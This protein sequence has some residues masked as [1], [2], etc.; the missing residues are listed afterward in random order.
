AAAARA[1][2]LGGQCGDSDGAPAYWPGVQVLRAG[3]AAGGDPGAAAMVLP[4]HA[5]EPAVTADRFRLFDAVV[6]F[7]A[8]LAGQRPVVVVLDDLHW[9]D[10]GSLRLLEFTAR[11]VAAHPVLLLGAY[12]DEDGGALLSKLAASSEQLRLDGLA[13]DDV[14]ALMALVVG[15]SPAAEVAADVWR[16]TGGNPFLVRELTRLLVAQGGSPTAGGPPPRV[17]LDGVADILERR[18]A[19]LSQRCVELLT[20]AAV[21]GPE[22]RLDVL[23]RTVEGAEDVAVLLEEAVAARVLADP[24]V[25]VG[26]YR[27]SHDLFRETILA[28]LPA[29][30]RGELHL[31]VGRTLEALRAEGAAVHPAELASHFA[32]AASTAPAEAVSYG[33]LAAED[34]TARLAFEEARSHFERA[35]AAL[36]LAGGADPA[37]RAALLLRLADARN[38]AGDAAQAHTAYREAAELARR[39]GEAMTLGE[40]A[41]GVHGLGWRNVHAEAIDLLE[42]AVR[43]LPAAPSVLRARLLAAL[44]RDLHHATDERDWERAPAL[45]EEAVAVARQLPD[46]GTLGFCLLALH[47]ARWRPGTAA[48][49]LPIV[50]E[51]LSASTAAGDPDLQAQARLLRATAL[52]ELGDPDGLAELGAYCRASDE[53]GHARARY[54]ALSRGAT[55]A[56]IAGDLP[57]AIALADEALALGTMIG[58]PD[59][60]GVH[61]TLAWGV[62][63]AGGTW[64]EDGMPEE[65]RLAS[66][67]WPAFPV[68][69]A[70]VAVARGEL[71]AAHRAL[72]ALRLDLPQ[73]YDLE[74]LAFTAYAVAAAGSGEQR[75]AVYELLL[76]HEGQHVVVGGCASYFGA[77]DHLLGCLAT[78]LGRREDAYG[79]F[80]R[81]AA[82]HAQLGA[83]G[84]AAHSRA[85]AEASR[86]APPDRWV[87]RRDGEVWTICYRGTESHLPDSK[88]LRDLA[89]LLARPGQAVHAVELHTGQPPRGGADAVLDDRAKAI[90]RRRLAELEAELDAAEADHDP[91][92]AEQARA[93]RDALVDELRAAVGLGGRDRRLGDERERARKAVS[94]RIRDAIARI[95][96]ADPGLGRH[97][98]D[99]VQTGT[100]CSYAPPDPVRW[101]T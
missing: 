26:P 50:D 32:G 92:R 86:A 43:A 8:G 85:E 2:V 31:A 48:A 59:A 62:A 56:L 9:A 3:A 93:E 80:Q 99:T 5:A 65:P 27:F 35:L 17:L 10:E 22:V 49:R 24:P 95:E 34:A 11:H 91:Y 45:A 97:L 47:D 12:R 88:G 55:L 14:T 100:W 6:S 70:C 20:I 75:A 63:R 33:I 98:H 68:I 38:R 44:A 60:L 1:L 72:A 23:L 96:R 15:T 81:A 52:I 51:M 39:S 82:L 36:E 25:A 40:A 69:R 13:H 21:I 78:A 94:A 28:G 66:E 84:W 73:H 71:D 30:Q 57:R 41:L 61:E 83:A 64:G 74:P 58:E 4:E 67:P 76:P 53:L 18:L 37:D 46:P 19:R 90:Y 77:V 54:G 29:Q 42:E 7:L 87:F 16:R 89:A 101:R 79:H